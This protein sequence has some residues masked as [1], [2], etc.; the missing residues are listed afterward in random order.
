MLKNI[1]DLAKMAAE[2]DDENW[3]FRIYLKGCE[4]EEVDE[5]VH[6]LA[7]KYFNLIDCLD[8]GNCCKM[9]YPV[10]SHEEVGQIS[11]E[12]GISIEE[13]KDRYIKK[14]EP[15]GYYLKGEGSCPFMKGDSNKCSI[16]EHRPEVCRSYPHLHEELF[17]SRVITAIN[18]T[19]I[20]PIVYNV[21]EELKEIMKER[22]IREDWGLDWN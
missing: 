21:M 19:H 22:R 20:C 10:I 7:D 17:V 18:N 12:L 1:K 5:I 6:E 9:T 11:K 3:D 14:E 4:P 13:F 16:Y 15:K 2:K 8:C